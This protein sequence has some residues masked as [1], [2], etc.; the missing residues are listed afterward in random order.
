VHLLF[1]VV[2]LSTAVVSSAPVQ[3]S[4]ANQYDGC[5]FISQSDVEAVIKEK[6]ERNPRVVRRTYGT[7]E[8]YGCTYRSPNFTVDVCLET[9]RDADGVKMYLQA[10]G[11]TVKQTTANSLK[12]VSGIGERAWWGP[13]NPTSGILHVVRGNDVFW[14]QTHGKGAGAGSLETT[15]AITEKAFAAYEKARK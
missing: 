10:L 3:G 11:T 9:G 14:V 15:R 4:S 8:N 1:G 7:V 2:L 5:A 13:I 6:L 12:P